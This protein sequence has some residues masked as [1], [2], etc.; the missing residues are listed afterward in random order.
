MAGPTQVKNF[1]PATIPHKGEVLNSLFEACGGNPIRLGIVDLQWFIFSVP[2]I[3]WGHIIIL[4][5]L[6]SIKK[7][8]HWPQAPIVMIL[9]DCWI[10]L[11]ES[12]RESRFLILQK[13]IGW[14]PIETCKVIRITKSDHVYVESG[15]SIRWRARFQFRRP[16]FDSHLGYPSPKKI[17]KITYCA[18]RMKKMIKKVNFTLSSSMIL[19]KILFEIRYILRNE[20]IH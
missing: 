2:N 11:L 8:L 5:P 14:N 17:N 16:R 7:N 20:S 19:L 13:A 12:W 3:F 6:I 10:I 15:W 18:L 1:W 9:K 4:F